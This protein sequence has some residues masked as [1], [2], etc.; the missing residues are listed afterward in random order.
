M[1]SVLL[2]TI[3]L[4]STLASSMGF[5]SAS[6]LQ[7]IKKSSYK[8]SLL[9][10]QGSVDNSFLTQTFKVTVKTKAGGAGAKVVIYSSSTNEAQ[11]NTL[12]MTFDG[13][14]KMLSFSTNFAVGNSEKTVFPKANAYE[15]LAYG[16]NYIL[17]H[18]KDF[19]DHQLVAELAQ[20]VRFVLTENK[21]T[22]DIHLIDFRVYE[23]VMDLDG[24]LISKKMKKYIL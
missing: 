22:M 11:P 16:P 20:E 12:A 7:F 1:E 14:A 21:I 24:K 17:D 13:S 6:P 18:I 5:A 15:L 8:L 2:A 9:V 19:S 10:K 4:A 3:L 23:V